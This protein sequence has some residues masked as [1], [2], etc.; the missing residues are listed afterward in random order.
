M[1]TLMANQGASIGTYTSAGKSAIWEPGGK[2]LVQTEGVETV[3]LTAT[4]VSGRWYGEIIA[5]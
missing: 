1:L 2:L 4:K 3:L 5:I